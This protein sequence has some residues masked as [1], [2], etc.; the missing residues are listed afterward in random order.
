MLSAILAVA[1]CSSEQ[2]LQ[3][4]IKSMTEDFPAEVGVAYICGKDTV[5][6]NGDGHFPMFSVVKFHQALAVAE[7]VR[8]NQVLLPFDHGDYSVRVRASE[9]KP[10]TW[11]P[12]REKFPDGGTFTLKQLLE[13]AL[14]ESDNNASDILFEYFAS[15]GQV[16]NCIFDCGIRDCGVAWTEDEQHEDPQRCY[17]NWTTPLAAARLLGQFQAGSGSDERLEFIWDTMAKCNTGAGRIP[18][19]ISDKASAIVHKTGTGFIL[20]DGTVT[21][22]NDIA[23]VI[24]PDGRHF[25]LAVFVKDAKCDPVECE[26]L[27]AKI[28]LAICRFFE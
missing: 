15:P 9:L 2:A 22:I 8:T 1:G 20:D 11:S 23:C 26:E 21:G 24:L 27:I 12:M 19:Y 18:K 25:E 4:K 14:V 13:Y 3:R 7:R 17:D 10:D 16:E 5:A 28:A 6:I